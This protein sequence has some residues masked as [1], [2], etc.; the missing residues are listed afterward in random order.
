M[1]SNDQADQSKVTNR[2][3]WRVWEMLG[4]VLLAAFFLRF[5]LSA[6]SNLMECFR[7]STLIL[8]LKL[9][10]DVF[11]LLTRKAANEVSFVPYDWAIA[12]AGTY[13]S[14]FFQTVN[15]QD[16]LF[17]QVV[18]TVGFSLQLLSILSLNRSF[19]I[20]AANRG[21]KTSGMYKFVRHPLYFAYTISY[22][23]FLLNQLTAYN[24]II[25]TSM[26]AFLYLRII[27]EERLLTQN[28]EYQE[29]CQQTR[30]RLIPF[31]I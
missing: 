18:Q 1:S 14:M 20:V 13:C 3:M 6:G 26:M 12:I 29:Y 15:G 7:I 11:F 17:G 2:N 9:S 16:H 28:K 19:G 24:C 30:Y 5:L 23:G 8:T 31:V 25:Y 4:N 22:F 21:I 27:A 10:L